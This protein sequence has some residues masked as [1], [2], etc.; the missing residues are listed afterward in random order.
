MGWNNQIIKVQ[1]ESFAAAGKLSRIKLYVN[2]PE[3]IRN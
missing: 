1:D 2:V 3:H